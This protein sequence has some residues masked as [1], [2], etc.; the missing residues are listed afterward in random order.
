MTGH[1]QVETGLER[2]SMLRVIDTSNKCFQFISNKPYEFMFIYKRQNPV[3][4]Y[5]KENL[6]ET[7]WLH[8]LFFSFGT[9]SLGLVPS[10]LLKVRSINNMHTEW[11]LT[12]RNNYCYHCHIILYDYDISFYL[13]EVRFIFVSANTNLFFPTARRF[14]ISD[15]VRTT[16][17]DKFST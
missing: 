2:R 9:Q 17:S 7:K 14:M 16:N 13:L 4:P 1:K 10:S 6:V 3:K 12:D 8:L 11:D 15:G 5:V